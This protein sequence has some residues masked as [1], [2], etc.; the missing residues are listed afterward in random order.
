MECSVKERKTTTSHRR[1][2]TRLLRIGLHKNSQDPSPAKWK[3]LTFQRVAQYSSFSKSIIRSNL[4]TILSFSTIISSLLPPPPPPRFLFLRRALELPLSPTADADGMTYNFI[5]LA[6]DRRNATRVG[7]RRRRRRRRGC[8]SERRIDSEEEG[9]WMTGCSSS[10][11]PSAWLMAAIQYNDERW[12]S[13]EVG[14]ASV[15]SSVHPSTH[16]PLDPS[17]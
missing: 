15:R 6:S 12:G 3:A 11:L 17:I 1:T 13:A 16:G 4:S 10:P 2:S 7:R 14:T 9:C 5:Q 8:Y